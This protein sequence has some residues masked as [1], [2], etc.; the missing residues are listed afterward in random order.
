MTHQQ[1]IDT[2]M[3]TWHATGAVNHIEVRCFRKSSGEL[4]AQYLAW[5]VI[6]Q[7]ARPAPVVRLAGEHLAAAIAGSTH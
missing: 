3:R 6:N 2:S 1:A 7:A 4:K 5:P